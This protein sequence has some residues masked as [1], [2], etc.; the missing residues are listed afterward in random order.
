MTG[1]KHGFKG[2]YEKRFVDMN[3]EVVETIHHYGG[4]YLGLSEVDFN[5]QK[6]VESLIERGVNQVYLVGANK[7]M[8]A[9]NML[10]D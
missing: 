9:C 3:M 7:T 5:A 2:Y 6:V 8:R 1:V 4:C 10:H